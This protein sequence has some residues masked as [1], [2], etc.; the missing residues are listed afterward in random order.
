MPLPPLRCRRRSACAA[1]ACSQSA[2][3]SASRAA[4]SAAQCRE[5]SGHGLGERDFNS[6]GGTHPGRLRRAERAPRYRRLRPYIISRARSR[7]PEAGRATSAQPRW[8]REVKCSTDLLSDTVQF[9][10]PF[11]RCAQVCTYSSCILLA[12]CAPTGLSHL[13][14]RMP[15]SHSPPRGYIR[16]RS[17]SQPRQKHLMLSVQQVGRSA[18]HRLCV[19]TPKFGGV[20]APPHAARAWRNFE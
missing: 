15:S 4:V 14:T 6:R 5:G 19:S 9:M 10:H 1:A 20:L 18:K 8:R 13:H 2:R 11:S 7:R 17:A 16:R 12:G 3:Y